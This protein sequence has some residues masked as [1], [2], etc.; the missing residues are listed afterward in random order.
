MHNFKELEAKWQK[1]WADSK[2]FEAN[3]SDKE[4]FF[5]TFP[6]PYVNLS[7]HIGHFYTI[8]RV[9]TFARYKR[10]KGFNVLFPQGWHCT[11]SPI[12]AAANR[13]KE[14]EPKI[15]ESLQ[16]EGFSDEEIKSF[17]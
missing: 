10:L 14:N 11:G 17:T 7:P 13:V 6:Y 4:K 1:K 3:I 5:L 9:E 16:K 8:M 15:I 2:I 12:V